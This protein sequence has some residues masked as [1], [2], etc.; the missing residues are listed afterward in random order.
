MSRYDDWGD[1][2]AGRARE[3]DYGGYD[4]P[5]A[6]PLRRLRRL[7]LPRPGTSIGRGRSGLT[8]ALGV[9]DVVFG[10][11]ALLLEF[12]LF[13]GFIVEAADR[14]G[15]GTRSSRYSCWPRGRPGQGW[16]ASWVASALFCGAAGAR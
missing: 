13:F 3:E 15:G 11:L 10:G 8:I 9:V 5:A 2:R 14:S 16:P 12:Y 1:D 4:A 6:A 7:R